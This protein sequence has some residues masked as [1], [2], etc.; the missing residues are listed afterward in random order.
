MLLFFL[1]RTSETLANFIHN[2]TKDNVIAILATSESITKLNSNIFS[3]RGRHLFKN[4]INI[5]DLDRVIHFAR[6]EIHF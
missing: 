4:V 5:A 1:C 6:L 2:Y 3:S